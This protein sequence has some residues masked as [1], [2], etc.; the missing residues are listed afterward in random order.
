MSA[1][2][3]HRVSAPHAVLPG[4][5]PA[6]ARSYGRVTHASA[7]RRP[8]PVPGVPLPRQARRPAP[9]DERGMTASGPPAIHS[10]T[11]RGT[12]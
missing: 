9:G 4:P 10:V 11:T 6:G 12:R 1:R 5:C 8:V 2:G 7:G 3:P